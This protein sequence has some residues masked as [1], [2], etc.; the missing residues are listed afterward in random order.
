MIIILLFFERHEVDEEQRAEQCTFHFHVQIHRNCKCIGLVFGL[1][2]QL[3]SCSFEKHKRTCNAKIVS[4][5]EHLLRNARPLFRDRADLLCAV[6][7][8]QLQSIRPF[9]CDNFQATTGTNR[10]LNVGTTFTTLVTARTDNHQLCFTHRILDIIVERTRRAR[11]FHCTDERA[12]RK[13]ASYKLMSSHTGRRL[14]RHFMRTSIA[15]A[16]TPTT[17]GTAFEFTPH[18]HY[19]T[20]VV[21]DY[22]NGEATRR[23]ATHAHAHVGLFERIIDLL[24]QRVFNLILVVRLPAGERL[25]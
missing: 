7:S 16:R 10:K 25:Q 8:V 14:D 15:R 9:S 12:C 6:L 3:K 4:R 24:T 11:L 21:V 19:L 22:M 20:I 1:L 5:R 17:S 13:F 2:L 23:S 18:N